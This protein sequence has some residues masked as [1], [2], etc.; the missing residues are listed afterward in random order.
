MVLCL[1]KS[2][3]ISDFIS[4]DIILA[5]IPQTTSSTGTS[6]QGS[7]PT[8]PTDTINYASLWTLLSESQLSDVLTNVYHSGK[9]FNFSYQYHLD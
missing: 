3:L 8:N 9:G 1:K 5:L 4:L 2:L 7:A 6:P